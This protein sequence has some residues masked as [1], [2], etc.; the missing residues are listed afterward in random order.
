VKTKATDEAHIWALTK[1][2][3]NGVVAWDAGYGWTKAGEIKDVQAW[4]RYLADFARKS[5]G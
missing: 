5:H 1:T 4:E 3:A 2:D